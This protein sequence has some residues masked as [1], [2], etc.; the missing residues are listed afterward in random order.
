MKKQIVL[1]LAIILMLA[2]LAWGQT[3]YADVLAVTGDSYVPVAGY[4]KSAVMGIMIVTDGV[5]NCTV[6]LKNGGTGGT[7]KFKMTVIGADLYGGR[8]WVFPILFSTDIY[9]DMTTVG[10]CT[11]YVEHVLRP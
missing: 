5:N 6:E 7:S 4:G 9:V 8:S 1:V 10:T 11:A 2:G 3:K